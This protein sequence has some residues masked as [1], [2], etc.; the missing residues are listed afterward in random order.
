MEAEKAHF[1]APRR[2]SIKSPLW[3]SDRSSVRLS[4]RPSHFRPEHISKSIEGNLLKLYTLK[5][6]NK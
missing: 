2:E 6:G 3:P 4:F 1:F 5:E